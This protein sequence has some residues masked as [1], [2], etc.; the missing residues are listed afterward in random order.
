[1]WL[2]VAGII[3]GAINNTNLREGLRA[4]R[5]HMSPKYH[6]VFKTIILYQM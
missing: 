6:E 2:I 5:T 1:M 3:H 4:T